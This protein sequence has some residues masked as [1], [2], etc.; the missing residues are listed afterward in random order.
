[1]VSILLS[2]ASSVGLI[3]SVLE[4]FNVTQQHPGISIP[5]AARV[6]ARK[7]GINI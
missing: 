5:D 4:V 6:A 7:Y 2:L 1:M 3:W